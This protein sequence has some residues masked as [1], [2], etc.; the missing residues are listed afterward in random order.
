MS[1]SHSPRII[2][3]GTPEFSAGI[4]K[5][6]IEQG[7]NI[8]AVY[9]QPDRRVGRGKK[10]AAGPVKQLALEHQIP[11]EQPLNFKLQDDQQAPTA[12]QT[13]TSYQADLMIVV[14][15][16]LLLPKTVLE[17]PRF[18]CVNIHASL[19][20]RWRGAAPIQRAIQAGDIKTGVTI[21]QMDQGLDTGAMLLKQDYTLKQDETGASLHDQ[22]AELGCSAIKEFLASFNTQSGS[23]F[24]PG[25]IQQDDLA[26][27]AHKLSKSEAEIDWH[28]SAT[29]IERKIRA[30]NAWPVAF[31]YAGPHRIRVWQAALCKPLDKSP[32]QGFKPGQ[33]IEIGKQ[34]IIVACGDGQVLALNYLQADGSRAMS[35]AEILNSKRSWFSEIECLGKASTES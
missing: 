34:Q 4:L 14:A 2:F 10:L 27:Y 11:V 28:E 5:S 18:G 16:G 9:C 22:L 31:T 35:V 30:F 20:P 19:L 12:L 15:Y 6:L 1:S 29:T 24:A 13:L 33:I 21:M 8:C 3:A 25:E 26:C 32:E 17:T 7:H 23:S